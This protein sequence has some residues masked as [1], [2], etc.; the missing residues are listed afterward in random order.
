MFSSDAAILLLYSRIDCSCAE[1]TQLLCTHIKHNSCQIIKETLEP[2]ELWLLQTEHDEIQLTR[3]NYFFGC[4]IYHENRCDVS[5]DIA[6]CSSSN[7]IIAPSV[8]KPLFGPDELSREETLLHICLFL[9][10]L[11]GAGFNHSK[12]D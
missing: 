11:I 9:A 5:L 2:Y 3:S 7:I 4:H 8:Q 6:H 1:R 10:F 12:K